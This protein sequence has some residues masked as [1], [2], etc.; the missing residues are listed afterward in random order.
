MTIHTA[1][2]PGSVI[3]AVCD[4][5]PIEGEVICVDLTRKI[6]VLQTTSSGRR[7]TYDVILVRTDFL[8][9]IKTVR[10]GTVPVY[11]EL[12]ISKL[13]ERIKRNER[14]QQEK[15]KFYRPG[16]PSEVRELVEHIEKTLTEVV[17]DD[18]NII[19][20]EHTKICP[21]YK[22][23]NVLVNSESTIATRQTAHVRKIVCERFSQAHA[24]RFK[25]STWI[26]IPFLQTTT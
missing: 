12:N 4:S 23:D 24:C 21:P 9:D 26:E 13:A 3:S 10:E 20:M 14:I 5:T 15:Q 22:E 25:D 17:W 2:K 8:R 18:P 16:V 6:I 11:P 19:V 1:L 7:D